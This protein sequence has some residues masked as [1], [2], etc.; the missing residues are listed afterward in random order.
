M[1]GPA[2]IVFE[3]IDGAGKTLMLKLSK[4][5]LL[6]KGV[7]AKKIL[8]TAE[9]TSSS[10][11]KKLRSLLSEEQDP[12]ANARVFL[13]LYLKDR[14]EHLSEEI[15]PALDKGKI[16]L[17]DRFK[18]ST[19]VYQGVQGIPVMEL[20]AAHRGMRVPDAVFIFDL[21]EEVALRRINNS[22]SRSIEKFEK[23]EFLLKVRRGFLEL[24]KIL[25]EEN[26]KVFNADK[27]KEKVFEEVKA[28]LSKL[29][30]F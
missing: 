4:E 22:K 12:K 11:G 16:V 10:Y 18:Y 17:C 26:I 5:F 27:P 28:E 19:I 15:L 21:P 7:P 25:P 23:K 24:R 2:F 3:G 8:L 14:K 9:P 6:E 29:L 13:E 30:G 1:V 20:I